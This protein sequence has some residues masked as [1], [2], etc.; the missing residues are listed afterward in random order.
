MFTFS[1]SRLETD[2]DGNVKDYRVECW[3]VTL[4]RKSDDAD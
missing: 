2:E 3:I 1:F 4:N